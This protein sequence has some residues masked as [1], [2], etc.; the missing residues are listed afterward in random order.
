M[1][2]RVF[3]V[4]G[5]SLAA[6]A[7]YVRARGADLTPTLAEVGLAGVALEAPEC[8]VALPAAQR[9]WEEAARQV[10]DPDFG[11]HFA[12]R[13]DLDAFH[14]VGHL[15]RTSRT[16]GEAIERIV[17]ASRLLHDAGRTEVERRPG[18]LVLY[19]GCRGLV[20]QPT[21]HV[22]EFNALSVVLLV[23]LVSH[24][25]TWHPTEVGF[26]H[27][28]PHRFEEHRRLFGVLPQFGANETTVTFDDAAL[29]L[30]VRDAAPSRLGVYLEGYARALLA[31]LP[32]A[33][34]DLRGHVLRAL[35]SAFP[36]GDASVEAVALRLGL[37]ARTLQRK[38]AQAAT[39]FAQLLDEAR[40]RTAKKYL[41]DPTLPLAEV[42]FLLGFRDP[43]TFHRA[44]RRW[45]GQTP[46]AWRD[47]AL[48][49]RQA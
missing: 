48:R 9:S 28:A 32:V 8:R 36:R 33:E 45:T 17:S 37:T 49:T 2:P 44:F 3:T 24:E 31:A 4:A 29:A 14:L 1:S 13:L 7:A 35:I 34:D 19:P 30:P 47:E 25:A 39:S 20:P 27:P 6:L 46:G 22:A 38:L 18:G 21:R 41:G 26:E 42:S 16:V 10:G 15:A 12:E 11:L 23:R 40:L 43:S 5:A